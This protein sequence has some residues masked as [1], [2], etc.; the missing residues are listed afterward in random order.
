VAFRIFVE[1]DPE[2]IHRSDLLIE[3]AIVAIGE[4][5]GIEDAHLGLDLIHRG[6]PP[7]EVAVAIALRKRSLVSLN[8]DDRFRSALCEHS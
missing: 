8:D 2:G 3:I 5:I 4:I 7:G 6:L 1:H